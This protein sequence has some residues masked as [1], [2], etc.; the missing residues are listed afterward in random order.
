LRGQIRRCTQTWCLVASANT[1]TRFEHARDP[2]DEREKEDAYH[3]ISYIPIDGELY[4]LDGLKST[5]ISH[6]QIPNGTEWTERAKEVITARIASYGGNEVMF[7]LMAICA[8]QVQSL[9][10][11]LEAAQSVQGSAAAGDTGTDLQ[12]DMETQIVGL[13]TRLQEELAKRERWA[14][15]NTLRRHNHLGLVHALLVALAKE[16]KLAEAIEESKKTRKERQEK[17]AERAKL[18]GQA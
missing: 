3:F 9:Q 16:G 18:A 12:S 5:P 8:D 6:G 14:F 1:I 13:Q 10:A 15:E 11:K 2:D 17:A 7:N 4:E